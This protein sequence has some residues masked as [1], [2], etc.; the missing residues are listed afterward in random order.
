M[1]SYQVKVI[2]GPLPQDFA[3]RSEM[4]PRLDTAPEHGDVMREL[5]QREPI[6]HRPELGYSRADFENLAAPEFW[7]TGASGRR[8]SRSFVLDTLELRYQSA[9]A[10]TWEIRDFHCSAIAENTFL[11]TYT[12]NQGGR[13]TRRCTIW[14][15]IAGSWKILYH[16]GTV[17]SSE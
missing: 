11:V 16:Q 13:V 6:F 8:Y 3:S 1:N 9:F 12:L 2:D 4:E 10:D 7:E 15:R 14:K 17:C 5:M